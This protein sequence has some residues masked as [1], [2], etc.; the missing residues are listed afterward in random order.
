MPDLK[1]PFETLT[2]VNYKTWLQLKTVLIYKLEKDRTEAVVNLLNMAGLK[3][4]FET[5]TH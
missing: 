1:C 5:L 3:C 4:R 2:H